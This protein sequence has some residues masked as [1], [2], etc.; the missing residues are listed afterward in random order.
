MTPK[1]T[2]KEWEV[3]IL[4][5]FIQDYEDKRISAK[6]LYEYIKNWIKGNRKL[7]E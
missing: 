4:K 3:K 2:P 6:V 7:Y 5:G 1:I